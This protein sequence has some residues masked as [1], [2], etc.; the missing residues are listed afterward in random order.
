MA[1]LNNIQATE[2]T[3]IVGADPISGEEQTPVQSTVAGALHVNLRDGAGDV[4]TE[5]NPIPVVQVGS[6]ADK[7]WDQVIIARDGVTQDI[8][9]VVYKKS[10][11]VVRTLTVT[12]DA[13]ENLETITK[14]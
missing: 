2:A 5:E 14:S 13:N 1:D 11:S 3:R 12:Y 8:I 4:F 7:D 10:S 6:A 9:S